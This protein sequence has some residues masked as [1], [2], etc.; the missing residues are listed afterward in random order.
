MQD[1]HLVLHMDPNLVFANKIQT[2]LQVYILASFFSQYQWA[3]SV[4]ATLTYKNVAQ[5]IHKF[6]KPHDTKCVLV[7]KWNVKSY[8]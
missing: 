5:K 2:F 8:K 1:A 6:H 7:Q 3:I 4:D